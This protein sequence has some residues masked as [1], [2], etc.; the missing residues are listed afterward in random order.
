MFRFR[1]LL[2][3]FGL[4]ML[5]LGSTIAV[6]TEAPLTVA[7]IK[8]VHSL[9]AGVMEGVGYPAL[10]V[11][12]G[13]SPHSWSLRPSDARN[14]DDA[15]VVVWIGG[16]L[17]SF[18]ARSL[19][20]LAGDA[21]TL[22]L[23]RTKGVTLL[24]MRE[25]GVWDAH[26]DHGE[27][28]KHDMHED[29][30]A[31]GKSGEHRHHN[32][33]ERGSFNMHLWLDPENATA[34][35]DAMAEALSRVDPERGGIYRK[36]ASGLRSRLRRLDTELRETLAP[37]SER[38]FIVFHDAWQYFDTRYG[39][40]AIGSVTV[41][42]EQLPGAARLTEIR[43]GLTASKAECV[44]AEPQFEPRLVR[45]LIAGTG[46]AVGALD[47]LGAMLDDGPDLYFELMRSNAASFRACF[48][49]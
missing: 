46:A 1:H 49:R 27:S 36:N 5:A 45:A 42:P 30:H 13:A 22:T 41:N 31:F 11:R 20:A 26:E 29:G 25:G 44:F 33:N 19:H 32:G 6:A 2:A 16:E 40:R 9:L 35:V 38:G 37:V 4:A 10:L 17:E 21:R 7:S 48:E 23:S 34:M 28:G 12:G 18:L 14:L 15:D 43:E 8:P 24:P 47:P 3:G 39:L